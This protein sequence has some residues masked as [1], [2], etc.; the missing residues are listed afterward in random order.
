M[1]N[2]TVWLKEDLPERF[3][4][5]Q[6]YRMPPVFLLADT[7]YLI[8]TQKNQYT[9]DP[10]K[11]GMRGNHGYDNKDPLM[12]PFMV[13]MGPDIKVMEGIQHM[14]QIDIYPLICGLLGL[15]RPNRIDGRLQRV[16]P[17][18]K[19]PPSEEFMRV[20]QKYE[21]GIMTHS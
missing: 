20:F 4:L 11:K 19:T 14:E 10:N 18:M 5:K 2:C 12:H 13:A 15:Q 3:H 6:S 9:S 17:F 8:N 16:V 21:T 7:G 1:T